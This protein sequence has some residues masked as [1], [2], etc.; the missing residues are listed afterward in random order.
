M[1]AA[2]QASD[3]HECPTLFFWTQI[4]AHK[5]MLQNLVD[6]LPGRVEAVI[7]LKGEQIHINARGFVMGCPVL[8]IPHTFGRIV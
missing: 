4:L 2:H 8:R 7:G 1:M 5:A 6:S 3:W